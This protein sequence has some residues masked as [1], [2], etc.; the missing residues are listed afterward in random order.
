M[1]FGTPPP[2]P[3]GYADDLR[4]R[5]GL[6]SEGYFL[7]QPTRI[8]PRKRIEHAIELTKRLDLPCTLVISHASGD[9]GTDYELHLKEYSKLMGVKTVFAANIFADQRGKTEDG[10]KIYSLADAYQ[11]ADLITYP[12]TVEGFGN[13]FLET[14]YYRRPIVMSTY[15]IFKTDIK[16]KGFRVIEFENFISENTVKEAREVLRNPDLVAEIVEYNYEL[17][18]RHYSYTAL[19]KRLVAVISQCMG[20]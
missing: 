14:L 18:R 12:S 13:A 10:Q 15:E 2:E 7:L 19:E 3:D 8:V 20:D 9:E 5:L 17:G 4:A 16:P 1:D 6:D 11:Q